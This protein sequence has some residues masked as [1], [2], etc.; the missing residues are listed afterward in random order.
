MSPYGSITDIT[1]SKELFS[2]KKKK[3][4]SKKRGKCFFSI[5]SGFFDPFIF[6]FM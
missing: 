4:K 6:I 2:S 5:F 3:I 1:E